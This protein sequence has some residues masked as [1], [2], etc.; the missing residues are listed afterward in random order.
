M[1]I[2]TKK[3]NIHR[4]TAKSVPYLMN[5][6]QKGTLSERLAGNF[7]KADDDETLI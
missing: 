1:E 4:V 7:G 6:E 5:E 3:L 2:F